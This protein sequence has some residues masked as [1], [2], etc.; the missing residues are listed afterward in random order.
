MLS[1]R[2][3][4]KAAVEHQLCELEI[5]VDLGSLGMKRFSAEVVNNLGPFL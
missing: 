4:S 5:L 2:V 3:D 1:K